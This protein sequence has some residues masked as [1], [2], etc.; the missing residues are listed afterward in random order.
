MAA[1][2]KRTRNLI[3]FTLTISLIAILG[4]YTLA[5]VASYNVFSQVPGLLATGTPSGDYQN[6]TFPSRGQNY[7]VYAFYLPGRAN[8]PAL[9]NVHGYKGTR[10]NEGELDRANALRALGYNVLSID[11]S[12]NGGDTVGNGR[13]SMGY[14]ERWDVLG[15]Y[16][17]LL[18]RGFTPDRV[19]L[20]GISMGASTNILAAAAEPRIRAVWADSGYARADVVLTE[21]AAQNGLPSIIVPG[22][23]LAGALISGDRIWEASPIDAARTLAGH[24]QAV[25]LIQ[26]REDQTVYFHHGVDMASAF[27]A[28]GVD[29]SFWLAEGCEHVG[30][31]AAYHDEYFRRLDTFFKQ[32]LTEIL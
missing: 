14:S 3:T 17:Y 6:M 5:C 25:Y 15:A 10:H 18:T 4:L 8:A 1:H 13:I 9:I 21:Q 19:G 29:V 7:Q 27:K 16:D 11:L 12:D 28:A 26:C 32:Y 31:S 22:G 2:T 24:R 23:L 30:A 20:V